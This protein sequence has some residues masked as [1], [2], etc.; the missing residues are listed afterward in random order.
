MTATR[1][2]LKPVISI[3]STFNRYF[4]NHFFTSYSF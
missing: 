4:F 3:I 2:W 1:I